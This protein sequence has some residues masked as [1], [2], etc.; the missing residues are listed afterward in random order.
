MRNKAVRPKK[1]WKNLKNDILQ[2]Y[3]LLIVDADFK[4]GFRIRYAMV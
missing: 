3:N 2:A 4:E 1:I